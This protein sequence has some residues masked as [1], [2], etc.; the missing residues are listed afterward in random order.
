MR[1]TS[2]IS[3]LALVLVATACGRNGTDTAEP[4]LPRPVSGRISG[5]GAGPE[6]G[7]DWSFLGAPDPELVA[8][9]VLHLAPFV[10]QGNLAD[11]PD[12]LEPRR[13]EAVKAWVQ[14]HVKVA[15]AGASGVVHVVFTQC[16]GWGSTVPSDYTIFGCFTPLAVFVHAAGTPGFVKACRACSR[17]D[18]GCVEK[19]CAP[20]LVE[21]YFTGK[22]KLEQQD[23]DDPASARVSYEVRVLRDRPVTGAPVEATELSPEMGLVLPAGSSQPDG[24]ILTD[25][26]RFAVAASIDRV[27]APTSLTLARELASRLHREGY[28]DVQVIDSRRVRTQWCCS[29]LVIAARLT[30]TVEAERVRSSLARKNLGKFDVIELY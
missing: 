21:G 4:K 12:D 3:G 5:P 18:E 22:T 23:P 30:S 29:H 17:E 16:V 7:V 8:A 13:G 1:V 26:P 11:D 19:W 24:P 14:E 2:L 10:A 20:R 6:A 28:T 9:Q 25:G 15:G 27:W